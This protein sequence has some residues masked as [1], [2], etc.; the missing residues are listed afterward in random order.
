MKKGVDI[1]Q[2]VY[3]TL[4]SITDHMEKKYPEKKWMTEPAVK[5]FELLLDGMMHQRP[6]L[7]YFFMMSP[8]IFR[9]MD[10]TPFG[11]EYAC[12]VMAT[13]HDVQYK[14]LDIASE[15]L[16][17]HICQVNKFPIGLALSGDTVTPDMMIYTAANPCDAAVTSYSN[18]G[19]Y[20]NIPSFVLDIPYLSDERGHKYVAKQLRNMVSFIEERSN[21][22][23]DLDR[24]KQVID[25]SNQA[26][27]YIAKLDNLRKNIPSPISSKAVVITS[28]AVLGLAGVPELVDWSR[29]QY[30]LTK[31]KM[32]RGEKVVS[33]EKIRL[34]W[35]A[36][37]IEF[38][39]SIY[40]WLES[41]CGAVTVAGI[42]NMFPT[43]P[44][45]TTGDISKIFEGLARKTMDYP[46]ARHGRVSADTYI[47]ECITLARDYKADAVVFACNSGCKYNWAIAQLVKDTIYDEL[48]IPTLSFEFSPWDPRNLSLDGV[49]AKF[50]QFFE[51]VL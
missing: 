30:E 37:G 4:R 50:E 15:K 21:Q 39:T 8:E 7:W 41:E 12:S 19:H 40:D 49:K 23:L 32:E 20:C 36:N 26:V 17:E 9:A 22:K 42:L 25:Y 48:G 10:I 29:K 43:E 18:L 33:E 47:N 46:M 31:E 2:Q 45:D 11:P 34:V 28:G 6:M 5:Y 51:L 13:L 14:Y 16:P 1:I 27:E 3:E 44:V 24:L 35:I 38:S